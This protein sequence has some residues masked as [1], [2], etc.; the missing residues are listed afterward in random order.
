M[1]LD[2][3]IKHRD[4]KPLGTVPAVQQ[5]LASAFP[6]IKFGREPSGAEKLRIATAQGI[7]FPDIFRKHFE[8]SRAQEGAEYQGPEFSAQFH[9]GPDE[10]VQQV[11]IVLYA[12]T[13]ASEPM[14]TLLEERYGWIT[15]YP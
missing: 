9:F 8:S 15:T 5:A 12:R 13:T 4:G 2:G 11:D 1:G 3:T 6:G 14:F 10:V 7:T